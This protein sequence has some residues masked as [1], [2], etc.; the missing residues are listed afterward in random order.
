M[1]NFAIKDAMD[2]KIKILGESQPMLVIDY[3][4][5]CSFSKSI[6]PRQSRLILSYI[7]LQKT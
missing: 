5:E 3:L 4:N 2:V 7:V 1:A 6:T